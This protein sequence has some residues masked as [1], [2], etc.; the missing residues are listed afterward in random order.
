VQNIEVQYKYMSNDG[1]LGKGLETVIH[2]GD[3]IDANS[4]DDSSTDTGDE[5]D[6][7]GETPDLPSIPGIAP[8]SMDSDEDGRLKNSLFLYICGCILKN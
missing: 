7:G 6:F 1:I 8:L 2:V 3:D 4:E 5:A